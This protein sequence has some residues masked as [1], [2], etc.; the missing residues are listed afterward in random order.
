M[1]WHDMTWH[2]MLCHVIQYAYTQHITYQTCYML[3]RQN[4]MNFYDLHSFL[5]IFMSF[6]ILICIAKYFIIRLTTTSSIEINIA[7]LLNFQFSSISTTF[8]ISTKFVIS[9]KFVTS[10]RQR[11]IFL[12]RNQKLQMQT[13]RTFNWNYETIV[14]HFCSINVNCIAKQI[15]YAKTYKFTSQKQ[16]C[17]SK[18][19]LNTFIKRRIIDF[20]TNSKRTKRMFFI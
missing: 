12:T 1:T 15:Q 9:M 16:R 11:I 13:F 4:Y 18:I 3:M 10:S 5:A 7:F 8:V 17:D 14:Q 19:L 2:N 6:F 20:I